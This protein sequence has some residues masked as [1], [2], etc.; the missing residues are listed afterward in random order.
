MLQ[1]TLTLE[2]LV[3]ETAWHE[4]SSKR[5]EPRRNARY[6]FLIGTLEGHHQ[7]SQKQKCS[8]VVEAGEI[9]RRTRTDAS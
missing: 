4:W 5:T 7:G 6:T 9:S 8:G 3:E 1:G 2:E